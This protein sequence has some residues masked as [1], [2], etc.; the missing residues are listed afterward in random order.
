MYYADDVAKE[1]INSRQLVIFG[2]GLVAFEVANCLMAEPYH[3]HID[4]FMV[5]QK[6]ENPDQVM[7]IPV[8]DLEAA[9]G[10]VNKDAT[11][12][13]ATMGKHLNSIQEALHQYSYFVIIPMT[14]ESDL[15]SLIQGNYYREYRLSCQKPY[16]T[17]E[18]E[19]RSTISED[20][21]SR[22]VSIYVVRCHLDRKLREDM[23]RFSWE[24][25]IQAGA[26]LADEYICDIRDDTGNNISYKNKQYC[27]LTALYWIWKNDTAD[28]T[29][30]C[31]YRRHF[32]LD[33]RMLGKL[34]HSGI[35]VVLTIPILNFTSVREVYRHDHEEK[36]WDVMLEAIR[37]LSP[38]Y[39][40]A[41]VGVQNGNYYYGY[42]MFIARKEILDDYCAW[43][44]PI[45]EYCEKKCGEKDNG[46]QNRYIGFLGERLLTIYMIQHESRFKIVH[47][48]KYFV[49]S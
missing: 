8:I 9:R 16:L 17:L 18:E 45:L 3:L 29:G 31:H 43:L 10:V 27:E 40:A 39:M 20:M 22:T 46:Y 42:N 32:E 36:D 33:K 44:F 21:E 34:V 26:A 7:G 48:R 12:V 38:D 47:A 13:V 19:L 11:I 37:T 24:I 25:P 28:Y 5:S 41:A 1:L 2:T 6:E 15:W 30:L 23:S 35:D 49:E 4:F 14:F